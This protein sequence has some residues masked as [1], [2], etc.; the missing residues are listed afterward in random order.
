MEGEVTV[1]ELAEPFDLSLPT[2]SR[3]IK[4]LE[5]AGLLVRKTEAQWRRCRLEPEKLMEAAEWIQR[6]R[7]F[8]E[9][10]LDALARFVEGDIGAAKPRRGRGRKR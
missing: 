3:H 10:R 7:A 6:Y 8:W 2:V 5:D 9:G 4:V 1:G